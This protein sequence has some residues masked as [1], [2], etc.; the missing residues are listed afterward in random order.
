MT[1]QVAY[2]RQARGLSAY[3]YLLELTPEGWM[4]T[5]LETSPDGSEKSFAV[6]KTVIRAPSTA[7]RGQAIDA[8]D[9]SHA[10]FVEM[11]S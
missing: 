2:I 11:F 7:T 1:N 5:G 4:S 3:W 6:I 10:E 8:M 9:A